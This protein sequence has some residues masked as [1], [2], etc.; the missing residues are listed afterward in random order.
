MNEFP[1]TP[2]KMNFISITKVVH[3]KHPNLSKT[4]P[5]GL[6]DSRMSSYFVIHKHHEIVFS[7]PV[8]TILKLR[9]VS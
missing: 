7:I 6:I 3:K 2:E 8:Q 9:L 4:L 1:N 5:S